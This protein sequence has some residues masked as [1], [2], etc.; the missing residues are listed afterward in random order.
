MDAYP[1]FCNVKFVVATDHTV[2]DRLENCRDMLCTGA[3][4]SLFVERMTK[5]NHFCCQ[6]QHQKKDQQ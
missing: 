4:F 2:K 3:L 1:F 5:G 6:D